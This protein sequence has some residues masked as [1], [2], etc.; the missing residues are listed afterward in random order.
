MAKRNKDKDKDTDD[1]FEIG[2]VTPT[3]AFFGS[4]RKMLIRIRG[5]KYDTLIERVMALTHG[6]TLPLSI[7]EGTDPTVFRN[8]V[9]SALKRK[10]DLYKG[11]LRFSI[12]VDNKLLVSCVP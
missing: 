7:P 9:S 12:T 6:Q 1:S 2:P 11:R 4:R 10:A 5:S 8:N 3:T